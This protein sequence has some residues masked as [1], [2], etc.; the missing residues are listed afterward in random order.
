MIK[1]NDEGRRIYIASLIS[2]IKIYI[3]NR[4][5][6]KVTKFKFKPIKWQIQPCHLLL[7][8]KKNP[9]FMPTCLPNY[10]LIKILFPFPCKLKW[11]P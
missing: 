2:E 9:N 3:A 10:H 7:T 11:L 8:L 1:L 4:C 5:L 6:S